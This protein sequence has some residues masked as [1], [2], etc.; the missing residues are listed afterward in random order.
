[1]I[2]RFCI[3]ALVALVAG[4]G[5]LVLPATV[6]AQ[7]EARTAAE[8]VEVEL[9][10]GWRRDD[11]THMAGLMIRLAPGWKTYWRAPGEAGIPP[12]LQLRDRDGLLGSQIHWPVP[13]VF[14]SNGM[15]SIG[16]SSDV[17]FPLE[18]TLAEGTGA[19]R[20]SGRLDIGVCQDI[21]MPVSLRLRGTLPDGGRPD[22]RIAAALTDRPLT[23][24]EA[25]A[26]QIICAL[27]PISDGLRVEARIPLPSLGHA[28]AVV[29]ELP[30]PSIWISEAEARRDGGMLH[31]EADI[32]PAAAGPFALDRSDLRIT[33]LAQGRAV[34]MT[35]CRGG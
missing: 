9:L 32:V 24:A 16:Y 5:L 10:E 35:G 7:T 19:L 29:F 20:L 12:Q 31:A 18:L 1:M 22:P 23:G 34:E 6:S 27:S 11:G 15:R 28:E 33:V 13:E 30:D 8:V 14:H 26:G 4:L 2:K 25:G 3:T 21:C 17:V